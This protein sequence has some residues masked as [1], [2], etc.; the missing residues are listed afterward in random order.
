MATDMSFDGRSRSYLSVFPLPSAK[1]Q[2]FVRTW[3]AGNWMR[4]GAVWSHV[5]LVGWADLALI[6]DFRDLLELNRPRRVE[7]DNDIERFAA[8]CA[9]ELTLNMSPRPD[10]S[11]ISGEHSVDPV[12]LASAVYS[13]S[14][15]VSVVSN[16]PENEEE[17]LLE[18]FAQQWSRLRRSFAFR[19]RYRSSETAVRFDVEVVEKGDRVEADPVIR[20]WAKS[21]ADDLNGRRPALRKFL[22]TYGAESRRG[23]RDMS[24]LVRA[25]ET[26]ASRGAILEAVSSLFFEFPLPNQMRR[27]KGDILRESGSFDVPEAVRLALAIRFSEHLDLG[28]LE[29]GSRFV[30]LILSGSVPAEALDAEFGTDL[31]AVPESQIEPVLAE[32][33]DHLD[34]DSVVRF[35]TLHQDLGLLVVARRPAFL[36]NPDVWEALEGES[37]GDVFASL[38]AAVQDE[39]LESLLHGGSVDALTLACSASPE[40]WWRL[41]DLV[42]RSGIPAA[43]IVASAQVLRDTLQRIGL[44]SLSG[45]ISLGTN[46]RYALTVLLSAPLHAGLWRRVNARDWLKALS[47]CQSGELRGAPN[48]VHE[49]LLAVSLVAAI[50]SGEIALR[51]R[52]WQNTFAPLHDALGNEYFDSEAWEVLGAALPSGPTWDRCYRLR[53][54]AVTEIRRDEWGATSTSELIRGAGRQAPDMAELISRRKDMRKSWVRDVLRI[55]GFQ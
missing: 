26:L 47:S 4:P 34:V 21:L 24:V 7:D 49:R 33:A 30:R 12:S 27:L 25:Q 55:L 31:T 37:V 50:Q 51:K 39:I 8:T 3:P 16:V 43:Q 29:V 48:W 22:H 17:V 18:L 38:A 2:A 14:R 36:F 54:G 10:P 46:P 13:S 23:R 41:V 11:G 19:T 20:D 6:E 9:R 42:S 44:A 40:A 15:T 35:A 28:E 45:K 5:V 1:M 53:R 32:I 52:G